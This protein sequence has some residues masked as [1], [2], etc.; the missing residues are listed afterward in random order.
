MIILT[1]TRRGRFLR[2]FF[3]SHSDYMR[4][5]TLVFVFSSDNQILLCLK[6]RWFGEGKRNGAWWKVAEGESITQA[7][8]RELY[9]E[10]WIS[11]RPDEIQPAG[12]IYFS[13]PDKPERDQ[14]C[15]IFRY[16]NY[17]WS[18]QETE[19]MKPKRYDVEK[20]PYDQMRDDDR[21]RFPDL[22]SFRDIA[23]KFSFDIEWHIIST[24]KLS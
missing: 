4:L 19:E 8:V 3:I 2:F 21:I 13:F 20:I 1:Y 16:D 18:F 23:Y 15:H 9:E 5:T 6:K 24:K 11:L 22:L 17:T 10:T 12:S 7:A 14:H